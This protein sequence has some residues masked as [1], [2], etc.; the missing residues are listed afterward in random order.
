MAKS[1]GTFAIAALAARVHTVGEARAVLGSAA[2]ML[3]EA[4]TKVPN[5]STIAGLREETRRQLDLAND[6]AQEVYAIYSGATPDLF[7]EEISFSNAARVGLA[8]ERAR[9]GLRQTEDALDAEYWNIAAVL[10]AALQ[11]AKSAV[12]WTVHQLANAAAAVTAPIVD[13]FWP[14]LLV[15]GV[16]AVIVWKY[17][18]QLVKTVGG[19]G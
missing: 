10:E 6:Y 5:V 11:S 12:E 13:A 18:G 19:V 15:A 7:D 8:L 4:Y 16:G 1:D 9:L 17:R 2:Q 3:Q 14:I